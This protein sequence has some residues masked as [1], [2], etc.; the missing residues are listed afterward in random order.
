MTGD[1]GNSWSNLNEGLATN[2]F[3]G[4]DIGRG[5]SA[6][7]AYTYGG[8]QDTGTLEHR[9]EFPSTDWHLGIDGDG[10]PVA[11]DPMNPLRAYG[12]DNFTFIKTTDGGNSWSGGAEGLSGRVWKVVVDPNDSA[13]VYATEGARL[14]KSTNMGSS[15]APIHTFSSVIWS[16]ATV[17]LDSNIL[18][19]GLEDGSVHSTA[20]AQAGAASTWSSFTTPG[21]AANMVAEGIAIDPT[22]ASRVA[23]AYAGFSGI[24]PDNR[25]KHVCQTLDNGAT[26][27]DISGTD[28]G[29]P[30]QNLPDLP[31]HDVVIGPGGQII[32][33]SDTGVMQT[34][35]SGATWQVLGEGLPTV[36]CKSLALDP[37]VSPSL[38]R[39]GTYGRSVFE[40]IPHEEPS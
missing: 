8:T 32:V 3:L 5:S 2:L 18:W 26:W 31:L 9:P 22:D 14:H 24:S 38:L 16:I 20:D 6:N 4:I 30:T 13:V 25:T 7:N 29:D 1:D 37:S 19:V 10:G 33:A 35:D 11:V 23:V 15:F 12:S 39:V 27:T 40:L 21:A 17:A 28:G 34:S 36:D